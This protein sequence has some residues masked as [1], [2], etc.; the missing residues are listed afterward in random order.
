MMQTHPGQDGQFSQM[1]DAIGML[2]KNDDLV[3][4]FL[5]QTQ[6]PASRALSTQQRGTQGGMGLCLMRWGRRLLRLLQAEGR[7]ERHDQQGK[8]A[9]HHDGRLGFLGKAA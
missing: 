3:A 9:M 1:E 2:Q 6:A 5:L 4:V 8:M 7:T